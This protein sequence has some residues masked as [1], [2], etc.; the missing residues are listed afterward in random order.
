MEIKYGYKPD[1][2]TPDLL[3]KDNDFRTQLKPYL[4]KSIIGD[5]D[6]SK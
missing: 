1:P 2:K 6:L 5:I 4:N 3:N